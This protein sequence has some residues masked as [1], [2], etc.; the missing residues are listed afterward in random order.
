MLKFELRRTQ[1]LNVPDQIFVID[2][3]IAIKDMLVELLVDEGYRVGSASSGADA[4]EYLQAY[5]PNLLLLDI[6]MPEMSGIDVIDNLR[7][8]GMSFPIIAVTATKNQVE[9]LQGLGIET[10]MKPFDI[11]H[12]LARIAF[13][14]S[15]G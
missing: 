15:C 13:Y 10:L 4:L 9:K 12:L 3:D 1:L 2:D 5:P 14:I 8:A 6:R 11:N 7:A